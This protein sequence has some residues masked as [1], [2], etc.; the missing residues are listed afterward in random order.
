M[1][2]IESG[3]DFSPLFESNNTIYIEKSIFLNK[4]GNG[5]KTVEFLTLMP[6]KKLYFVEAKSS[7]PNPSNKDDFNE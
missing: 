4:L 1:E 6:G 3:M 5:V 2:Y 7:A